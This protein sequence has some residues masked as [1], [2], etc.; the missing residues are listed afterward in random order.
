MSK[1]DIDISEVRKLVELVEKHNLDEL[2]VEEGDLSITIKGHAPPAHAPVVVQ[3]AAHVAQSVEAI[4]HAVPEAAEEPIEEPE[5]PEEGIV[6]IT[7]PVV[8]VFYRSP[9]PDAPPFV[10]VGDIVEVGTEVGL[11]EA[12]KVFS[13][14]PTEVAGEVIAIPTE[15]GTLVQEGD[16]LVRIRVSEG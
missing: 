6:D 4:E 2:T 14:V 1:L 9:S 11:I 16:V 13:P 15:N 3:P 7:A 8:G 5:E 12:M 10:E